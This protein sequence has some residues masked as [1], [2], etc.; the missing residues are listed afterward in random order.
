MRLFCWLI[1][2]FRFGISECLFWAPPIKHT[3]RDGRDGMTLFSKR[4]NVTEFQRCNVD[5]SIVVHQNTATILRENCGLSNE[6][7]GLNKGTQILRRSR[8]IC[9]Q[10][11]NL[12]VLGSVTSLKFRV[13]CFLWSWGTYLPKEKIIVLFSVHKCWAMMSKNCAF[14]GRDANL[15][16]RSFNSY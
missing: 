6:N 10:S 16:N 14:W 5:R 3:E 11:C 9:A 1:F 7:Q 13:Q 4:R 15:T 2:R 12:R 8:S